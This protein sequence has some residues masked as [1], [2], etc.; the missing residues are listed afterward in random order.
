MT[1]TTLAIGQVADK[2]GVAVSA[3]RYYEEIGLLETPDRVGGKRRFS[4]EAVGRIS[5]VQRAKEVGFTLEQI[6]LILDDTGGEWR[7]L[8]DGKVL[9]LEERRSRLDTMI[10]LLGE[11][12]ECGCE[13]V[14]TCPSL[15][16]SS[17]R[18]T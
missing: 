4:I 13:A 11:M 12:R 17:S 14:A 18:H 2:T 10:D 15:G 9:E 3:I 6:G 5:F 7:D 16:A 1:N 8:L